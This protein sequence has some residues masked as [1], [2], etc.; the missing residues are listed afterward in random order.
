LVNCTSPN[1]EQDGA[2]I[3]DLPPDPEILR[4]RG[5]AM[6]NEEVHKIISWTTRKNYPI[7]VGISLPIPDQ[8]GED[9]HEGQLW[10][11]VPDD[12]IIS[13]RHAEILYN[14][15][16]ERLRGRSS[17]GMLPVDMPLMVEGVTVQTWKDGKGGYILFTPLDSLVVPMK[18]MEVQVRIEYD[19]GYM[20]VGM[21]NAYTIS[22]V[23]TAAV[24]HLPTKRVSQTNVRHSGTQNDERPGLI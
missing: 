14:S 5:E 17:E 8:V 10:E 19:P 22:S 24:E 1:Q 9:F 18:K 3:G 16:M 11:E 20:G 7:W 6:R 21:E 12:L 2:Q 4:H 15:S 23:N 13:D